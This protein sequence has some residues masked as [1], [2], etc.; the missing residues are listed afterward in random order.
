MLEIDP[1]YVIFDKRAKA[2][3]PEKKNLKKKEKET[4]LCQR[5]D[6]GRGAG[7]KR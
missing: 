4:V 7:W 5:R 6:G 2:I 3:Q 1:T